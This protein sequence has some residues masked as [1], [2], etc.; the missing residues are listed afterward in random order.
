MISNTANLVNGLDDCIRKGI[1]DIEIAAANSIKGLIAE[2]IFTHNAGVDDSKLFGSYRSR[3]YKNKREKAGL[4]T[5]IKDLE[6]TSA[7]RNDFNLGEYNGNVA[8]GFS[9]ERSSNIVE[10]QESEKQIGFPIF[11]ANEEEIDITF[12]NEIEPMFNKMIEECLKV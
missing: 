5:K 3:S 11:S 6:F 10:G 4:Q 9:T 12:E 8:I 2:R 1:K 7:L